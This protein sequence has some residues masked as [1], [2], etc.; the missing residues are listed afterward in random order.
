MSDHVRPM[1]GKPYTM[2]VYCAITSCGNEV[3]AK[4]WIFED[5]AIAAVRFH[6]WSQRQSLYGAHAEMLCPE[7]KDVPRGEYYV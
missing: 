4:G 5:A 1:Q 7:H 2:R 3:N 6:D